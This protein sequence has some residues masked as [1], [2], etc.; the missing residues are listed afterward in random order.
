MRFNCPIDLENGVVLIKGGLTCCFCWKLATRILR[1]VPPYEG[2]PPT[3]QPVVY[4]GRIYALTGIGVACLDPATGEEIWRERLGSGFSASPVVAGGK[5]YV[6][7]EDGVTCVVQLGDKP[8]ILANNALKGS[9]L[10]TPAIANGAIYLRTENQ[11]Y[12][13]GA[14]K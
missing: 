9:L 13:I 7:K 12:C 6:A 5:L 4:Q 3:R 10:A 14:K 1:F 8:K 11:L 2:S